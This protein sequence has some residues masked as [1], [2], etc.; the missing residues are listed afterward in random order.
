MLFADYFF[1]NVKA[2]FV[3]CI[4]VAMGEYVQRYCYSFAEVLHLDWS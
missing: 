3:A 1:Y 2:A 4:P